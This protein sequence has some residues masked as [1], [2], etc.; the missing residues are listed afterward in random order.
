MTSALQSLPVLG[1]GLGIAGHEYDSRL[2]DPQVRAHVDF[3]EPFDPELD[4]GELASRLPSSLSVSLH[5]SRLSPIST[6]PMP[7]ELLAQTRA[8][9]DALGAVWV[10]EDLAVWRL[11]GQVPVAGP[12][13]P[14][15]LDERAVQLVA[16]RHADLCAALGRPFL[17]ELPPL[18]LEIGPLRPAEL[19]TALTEACGCGI[20]LDVSHWLVAAQLEGIDPL[21][22]LDRLP[23]DHVVELHVSGG[24]RVPGP[25]WYDEEHGHDLLPELVEL[26]AHAIDRCPNLRSV[27][28]E[29]HSA[30]LPIVRRSL[31]ALAAL[32]GIVA[33]RALAQSGRRCHRSPSPKT[34]VLERLGQPGPAS[35]AAA[36]RQ[37]RA[38]LEEGERLRAHESGALEV[39]QSLAAVPTAAWREASDRLLRQIRVLPPLADLLACTVFGSR[40]GAWR[41][42]LA[43]RPAGSMGVPTKEE[44]FVALSTM[45][46]LPAAVREAFAFLHDVSR[47]AN[48]GVPARP[49]GTRGPRL[50]VEYRHPVTAVV[51][52]VLE[53]QPPPPP[54][55]TTMSFHREGG[56][57]SVRH[58]EPMEVAS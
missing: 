11:E 8:V 35:L 46:T 48:R 49:H 12:F 2:D 44:G 26:V 30:Q 22:C 37:V 47:V 5:G 56:K 25:R 40:E 55:P 16:R 3:V 33:L 54:S 10:V 41:E 52:A 32:P 36:Q 18:P 7:A 58:A 57:L 15:V 51:N 21:E 38:L 39:D 19:F 29:C 45:P 24:R 43:Q 34:A 6:D 13:W 50:C 31:S 4:F 1:L 53:G 14:P 27:V 17:C 28:L 23:L 20:V 9:A 42:I